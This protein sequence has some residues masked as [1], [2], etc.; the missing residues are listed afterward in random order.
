MTAMANQEYLYYFQNIAMYVEKNHK[1]H[2]LV[3]GGNSNQST[4]EHFL[5]SHY[6]L[7]SHIH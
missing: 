4:V 7:F 1:G 2:Y 6:Q 3:E 5:S